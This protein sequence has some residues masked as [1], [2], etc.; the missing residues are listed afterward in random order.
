MSDAID[1]ACNRFEAAWQAA[2]GGG[3]RPRIEDHLGDVPEAERPALLGELVLLDLYYRLK[4]GEQLRPEDYRDRFPALSVGWLQRKIRREEEAAGKANGEPLAP[5]RIGGT[6]AVRES[7]A[8]EPTSPPGEAEVPLRVPGYEVLGVLGK[9]GMGIVYKARQVS[10]N[11][12][13]ALKMILHAEHA[14]EDERRRF[15]AEAEAVARLQHPNIVRVHEVGEHGGLPYFS[16]EFC[17]G[18]SLEKRLDGT[19]WEPRR[20]ARLVETLARAMHAAHQKGLVHRDLKPANVL[21]AEDGTPQVSDFGLAKCLD[22]PGLTQTGAIVGTPSY[23][24]PE[25]ASGRKDIGPAADVYALGAILYELLTGRPPFKAATPMDTVMQVLSGEAVPV[26]RLQPKVPKDLETICLKCLEKESKKRYAS[27]EEL[28]EDLKCWQAGEPIRARPVGRVERGWKWVRRNPVVAGLAG[29]VAM[30]LSAGLVAT[31]IYALGEARQRQRAEREAYQARL[32]AAVTALTE[33]DV[34]EARDQLH[35]APEGLRGWEW[36]H[37]S[38]RA[39]EEM[40]SVVRP[41]KDYHAFVGFFEPDL[42]LAAS[43]Q[44]HRVLLVDMHKGAVL[45]ELGTGVVLPGVSQTRQGPLLLAVDGASL[46]LVCPTGVVGRVPLPPGPAPYA[47][48]LS[49]DGTHLALL[50]PEEEPELALCAVVLEVPSGKTHLK[51]TSPSTIHWLA[52]SPDGTRLAAGCE[53]G[54]VRLWDATSGAEARLLQGHTRGWSGW[55]STRGGGS[56]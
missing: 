53:D 16:L 5:T 45:R 20:A 55:P 27:A 28:A 6:D 46:S 30:A 25:Q 47:G 40:P 34:I 3:S 48:V 7:R 33:H 21:L 23:M 42:L 52:F 38:S 18:G 50:W 54:R 19:P 32:A 49:P 41:G 35:A 22:V 12:V 11:R 13:V 36:H 2:S 51:L 44:D 31:T 43:T 29:A 8:G 24:A 10:L 15:Q 1:A 4:T 17:P 56:W 14:T 9:G 37:L 39:E 26:R